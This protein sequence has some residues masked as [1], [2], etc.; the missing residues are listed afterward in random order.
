MARAFHRLALLRFAGAL[1]V[2]GTLAACVGPHHGGYYGG[3]YGR[4]YAHQPPAYRGG[5]NSGHQRHWR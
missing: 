4:S 2:L 5:W 1:V 3:G